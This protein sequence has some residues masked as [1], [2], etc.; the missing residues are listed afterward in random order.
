[1]VKTETEDLHPELT[2][3]VSPGNEQSPLMHW[4][5]PAGAILVYPNKPEVA[6]YTA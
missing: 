4:F 3:V 5:N 6:L 1:M 2:N